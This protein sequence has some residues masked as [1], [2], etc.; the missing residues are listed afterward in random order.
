MSN[1][2]TERTVTQLIFRGPILA[3]LLLAFLAWGEQHPDMGTD[4]MVVGCDDDDTQ[5]LTVYVS[6]EAQA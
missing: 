6:L 3:D 2:P 5:Y 1:E 4:D